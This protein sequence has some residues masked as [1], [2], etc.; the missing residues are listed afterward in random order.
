MTRGLAPEPSGP[1]A[2]DRRVEDPA[3]KASLLETIPA[4]RAFARALCKQRDLADDLAQEALV[5]AWAARASYGRG[6]NFKAWIFTIVRNQFFNDRRKMSRVADWDEEAMERRLVS[7]PGQ[8]ASIEI[9]DL[10]RALYTLPAEQREALILVGAGGFRYEE[11][12]SITACAVGTV[13]SRVSRARATLEIALQ[14]P[15]GTRLSG[16]EAVNEI[17]ATLDHLTPGR[18]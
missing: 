3:F 6:T 1:L 4:V 8:E 16:G 10:H 13:K 5:K 18:A 11:A 14:Q 15:V 2:G 7:P 17:L 9:A 12:A